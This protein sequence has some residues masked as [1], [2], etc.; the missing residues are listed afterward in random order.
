MKLAN[1]TDPRLALTWE[2][3]DTSWMGDR[4]RINFCADGDGFIEIRETKQGRKL[5]DQGEYVATI[6]GSLI[7]A[8]QHAETYMRANGYE[9]MYQGCKAYL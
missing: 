7:D 8:L 1:I 3:V 5:F 6:E 4:P 2:Q 9:A